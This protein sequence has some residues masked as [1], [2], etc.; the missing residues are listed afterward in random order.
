MAEKTP[1]LTEKDISVDETKSDPLPQG[2]NNIIKVT[3][4]GGK[5]IVVKREGDALV[6]YEQE[7][8]KLDLR[9]FK[10]RPIEKFKEASQQKYEVVGVTMEKKYDEMTETDEERELAKLSNKVASWLHAELF[11]VLV[12][13]W[14]PQ[15][16]MVSIWTPHGIHVETLW[17]PVE[18]T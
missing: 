1:K 12:S 14:L 10:F 7:L 4:K 16:H 8:E 18:T 9:E 3:T 11:F 6:Q 17:C 13:M 15:Q 5:A 2:P